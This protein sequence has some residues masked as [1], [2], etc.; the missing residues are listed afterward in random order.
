[1]IRGMVTVLTVWYEMGCLSN[2]LVE[3]G[4]MTNVMGRLYKF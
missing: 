1:M 2:S 4:R 3:A